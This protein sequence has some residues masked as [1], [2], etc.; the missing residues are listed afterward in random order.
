[1]S[2][3]RVVEGAPSVSLDKKLYAPG[4]LLP[5]TVN[6]E[7][8]EQLLKNGA[9]E[10]ASAKDES[11]AEQKAAEETEEQKAEAKAK[12]DA[13]AKAAEAQKTE[14]SAPQ[15]T[16]SATVGDTEGAKPTTA[17]TSAPSDKK[18]TGTNKPPAK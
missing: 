8:V 6:D 15:P 13:N 18:T 9:I 5:E 3:Y 16:P 12:A 2:R 10:K 14:A 1:M 7:A 4:E 17:V 11:K